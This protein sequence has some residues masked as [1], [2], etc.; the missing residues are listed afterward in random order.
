MW[1]AII[2][3]FVATESHPMTMMT[4]SYDPY[5]KDKAACQKYADA[6]KETLN[7]SFKDSKKL[8]ISADQTVHVLSHTVTCLEDDS[9]EEM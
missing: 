2:V 3:L 4:S 9:G 5:F 8:K 7:T 6:R 1:K